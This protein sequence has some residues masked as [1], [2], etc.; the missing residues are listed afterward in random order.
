MK[1]VLSL[2]CAFVLMLSA[3]TVCF[4]DEGKAGEERSAAEA[5]AEALAQREKKPED[6]TYEVFLPQELDATSLILAEI[7]TGT[8][9]MEYNADERLYPASV[10]KIMTMLL[11]MRALESGKIS[12]EDTVAATANACSKGG[13]QIWLEEGETMTVRE[14]LLA[15]AVGSANDAATLLGEHVAGSEEA[16]VDMMNACAEELGM[17]N[18]HFDNATGLDDTSE[19]HLT[20]AR[21]I[22]LMSCELM[23][24]SEIENFTTVWMD[25]LRNGETELVNT[26]KLVRFYTG[27][28][29]IKTGTTNKA[30]HCVSASA[31]RDGLHLVAV[32]M[33]SENATQRFE[34]AKACLNWG[35]ANY[36]LYTPQIDA[37]LLTPAQIL[38]GESASLAPV[39]ENAA[40]ILVEKGKT[41]EIEMNI[42]AVESMEAPVEEGQ[43]MGR[44]VFSI[45]GEQI[46]EYKLAAPCAVGRITVRTVLRRILNFMASGEIS[47]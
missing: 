28:T 47:E 12:L 30:G 36:T 22:A 10:T 26:N 14:L 1:R 46:A 24:Y 7:T 13:S 11:V 20:T 5:L 40:P 4:A 6:E 32:I 34:A 33:G 31:R 42:E 35:F 18:T 25:T 15:T 9:L 39:T 41:G 23:K 44:I 2:V 17:V 8:V 43:S 16:F 45:N 27:T 19:T 3:A 21:D 29:G 37:S 38:Y